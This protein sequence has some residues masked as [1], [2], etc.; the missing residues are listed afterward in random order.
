MAGVNVVAVIAAR[1]GCAGEVEGWLRGLV[2][3]SR[4]DPGCLRYD[5]HRSL[6][7]EGV[8][9]FYETWESRELLDA[10]LATPHLAAWRK[11]A[12]GLVA[13]ADVKVLEKLA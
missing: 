5:L 3:P 7:E 6:D 4:K 10:H 9:V 13:G 8:F 2:E 11:A 12:E 1:P